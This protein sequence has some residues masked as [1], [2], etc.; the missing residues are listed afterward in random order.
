M[1]SWLAAPPAAYMIA[2]IQVFADF[3][4][5]TIKISGANVEHA[6][7]YYALIIV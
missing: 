1:I 3:P 6:M 7:L 2:V 5:A 4:L